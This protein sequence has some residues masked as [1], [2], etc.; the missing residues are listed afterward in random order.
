M[1]RCITNNI[2][3]KAWNHP[4]DNKPLSHR[5]D[6]SSIR[7]KHKLITTNQTKF[8]LLIK[9]QT[10]QQQSDGAQQ[11]SLN[12]FLVATELRTFCQLNWQR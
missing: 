3:A 6:A 2:A 9:G 1:A 12:K 8:F 10:T 4:A 11:V 7:R 5:I